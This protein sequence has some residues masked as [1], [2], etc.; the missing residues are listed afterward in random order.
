MPDH[1][2]SDAEL[3]SNDGMLTTVW[4]PALW[5]SLHTISFN[6]PVNPTREQKNQYRDFFLSLQNVLPCGA[7]R[8]NLAQNLQ[9]VPLTEHCLKNRKTFS[10]WLYRLHEQINTMLHK[11][12]GLTY[13]DVAQ[14][15]EMFRARCLKK[16]TKKPVNIKKKEDG[17]VVPMKGIRSKCVITIVP[18]ETNCSSFIV[19]DSCYLK[20]G[21]NP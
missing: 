18:K 5:H 19:D 6:Y 3:N 15:Y 2:F 8:K 14:R 10:R 9:A 21:P 12:S 11:K 16:P 7:C 4:G 1:V 13:D 17:C 20:K